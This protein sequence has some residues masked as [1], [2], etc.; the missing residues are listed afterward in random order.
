M[1]VLGEVMF[2]TE[3]KICANLVHVSLI[4]LNRL[5]GKSCA[6]V[7]RHKVLLKW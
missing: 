2:V 3:C 6:C 4:P 5:V 7:V 1:L